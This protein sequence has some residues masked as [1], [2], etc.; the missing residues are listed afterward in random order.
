MKTY[1]WVVTMMFTANSLI[2]LWDIFNPVGRDIRAHK[3]DVVGFV[4]ALA[5][6]IWGWLVIYGIY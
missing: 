5:I 2:N 3:R 4:V 6:T 1:L